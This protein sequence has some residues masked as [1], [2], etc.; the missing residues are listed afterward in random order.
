MKHDVFLVNS[1]SLNLAGVKALFTACK[2]DWLEPDSEMHSALQGSFRIYGCTVND[3]WVGFARLI[4]DGKIC[5]LL[6]DCM[7]HPEFRRRGIGKALIEYIMDDARGNG[8]KVIQLLASRE[9]FSLYQ[10]S[11]F[12]TCPVSA[13]GM[14]KFLTNSQP[15]L[16]KFP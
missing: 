1:D 4:S 11:G 14:V 13:P 16:F 12:T 2:W 6:I 5:G 7:V 3:K 8:L 10:K 9:G 15:K